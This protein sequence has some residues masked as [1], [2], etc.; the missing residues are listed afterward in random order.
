MMNRHRRLGLGLLLPLALVAASGVER[1]D[2]R[3][4]PAAAGQ[5]PPFFETAVLGSGGVTAGVDAY[6]D[7]V[8]LRERDA[9]PALISA[10]FR[11]QRA[12]TVPADTGIRV[13]AGVHRRLPLWRAS[14]LSQHYVPGTNVLVTRAEVDGARVSLTQA[15][16][17]ARPVLAMLVRAR[18][19]RATLAIHAPPTGPIRI[20]TRPEPARR[21][22]A[23][24]ARADRRWLARARPLGP[25]APRW[26]RGL[27]A[28]S[29]LVLQALTD[30]TTGAQAAGARDFWAYVWPRDAAAGALALEAAGYREEAQRIAAFLR[31]LDPP[32]AARFRSNRSP[33]KEDGRGAPGDSAGWIAEAARAS[34]LPATTPT[35]DWR[36]RPDYREADDE[37]ADLLGNAIAAGVPTGEL[38]ARFA[39]PGGLVR[40]SD[41]ASSGLD[42][43]AAWAVIP[44][45]RT[46]MDPQVR[47]T[48][49]RLSAEGGRFGIRPAESW[50]GDDPWTASTAWSAAA[51]ATLGDRPA[52][53]RLLASLRRAETPA[54]LLPERISRFS[55]KPRSTTPL[56]WS[57]AWAILALRARFP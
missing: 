54:G 50:P 2:P 6:G 21:I 27:Q 52:A 40:T 10:P 53:D 47:Q 12:G 25:G 23:A 24:A 16:D 45:H 13:S 22:I 32:A 56:A 36:N 48:L 20:E 49:L 26:A 37:S 42:S 8:D 29:L 4:P 34:G 33:V 1:A 39:S 14:K 18:P 41:N 31:R 3:T 46:G 15:A 19:S 11:R 28:R 35:V 17:P 44:F 5:T 30:R 55:G 9:G 38:L 7:V 51:L 43:A 57:H